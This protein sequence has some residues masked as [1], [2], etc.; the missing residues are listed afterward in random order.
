MMNF[1]FRRYSFASV[2]VFARGIQNYVIEVLVD[3]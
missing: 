3:L 1:I 2:I